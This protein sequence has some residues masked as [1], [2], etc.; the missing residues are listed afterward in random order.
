MLNII[1]CSTCNTKRLLSANRIHRWRCT[2]WRHTSASGNP[3]WR[4]CWSGKH[5]NGS[6]LGTCNHRRFYRWR[7][8]A[9]IFPSNFS[10]KF[11]GTR[12]RLCLTLCALPHSSGQLFSRWT[13]INASVSA[14]R[15]TG[16]SARTPLR[17]KFARERP[18]AA[19]PAWRALL[20]RTPWKVSP[21][22]NPSRRSSSCKG[23]N[24]F[25]PRF[26]SPGSCSDRRTSFPRRPFR[27]GC[28]AANRKRVFLCLNVCWNP[29]GG[30]SRFCSFNCGSVKL[31]ARLNLLLLNRSARVWV[32][33]SKRGRKV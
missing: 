15:W 32:V 33:C 20:E 22:R 14:R 25:F 13:T 8:S 12:P 19:C 30:T 18:L 27:I 1:T 2:L 16:T 5:R 23:Q 3:L 29:V 28:C 9:L 7:S 11:L 17:V 6:R 31:L 26:L 4:H 24:R 10:P 21:Y